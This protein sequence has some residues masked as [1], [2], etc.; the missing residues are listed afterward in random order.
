MDAVSAVVGFVLGLVTI[1]CGFFIYGMENVNMR[2]LLMF[3]FVVFLVFEMVPILD[4]LGLSLGQSIH[5]PE[6]ISNLSNHL[7]DYLI[8][9]VGGV[10]VGA[11]FMRTL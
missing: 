11:L 5:F 7:G 6:F 2:I 10:A 8:G 1:I 4:H 3:F 9:M